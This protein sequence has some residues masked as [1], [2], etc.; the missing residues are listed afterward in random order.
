MIGYIR[1]NVICLGYGDLEPALPTAAPGKRSPSEPGPQCTSN[2]A[3]VSEFMVNGR[4]PAV[5]IVADWGDLSKRSDHALSARHSHGGPNY[6]A[7]SRQW[8]RDGVYRARRWTSR[9]FVC[10]ACWEISACG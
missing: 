4:I 1:G 6:V 3:P 7:S 5:A 9:W 2:R 8:L 10:M